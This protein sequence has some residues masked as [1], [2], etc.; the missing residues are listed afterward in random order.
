MTLPLLDTPE[1]LLNGK[2]RRFMYE[3]GLDNA[4]QQARDVWASMKQ[5][6]GA[7]RG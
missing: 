6:R 5:K 4:V 1:R 2:G 7:Q 3:F